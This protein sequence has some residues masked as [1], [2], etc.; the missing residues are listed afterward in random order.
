MNQEKI[1]IP[2]TVLQAMSQAQEA[3]K[4][5]QETMKSIIPKIPKINLP[6]LNIP[7]IEDREIYLPPN[8]EVIREENEWKRHTEVIVTQNTLLAVLNKILDEQKSTSKMTKVIIWLTI[9]III[10]T[11]TTVLIAVF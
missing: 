7:N 6:T 1:K 4:K 10:L 8:T 11:I 3:S 2:E 9:I 5:L